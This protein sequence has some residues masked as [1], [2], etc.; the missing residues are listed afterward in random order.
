M[1]SEFQ[2]SSFDFGV[3]KIWARSV[4]VMG[5]RE[6]GHRA[7]ITLGQYQLDV[8]RSGSQVPLLPL[9]AS[10]SSLP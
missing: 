1:F 3:C 10:G 6:L 4:K 8:S 9:Q 2:Y 5:E 7:M